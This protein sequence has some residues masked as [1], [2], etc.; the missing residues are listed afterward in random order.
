MLNLKLREEFRGKKLRG[1]MVDFTNRHG[2]G[3]LDKSAQEFLNITYPSVD[4]LKAVEALQPGKAKP[5]VIIGARGLGKSHLMA[6]LAHMYNDPTATDSWLK[7]WENQLNRDDLSNLNL[8]SN[9]HA[10]TESLHLHNYK[11]LWD[12]L[13]DKHPEGDYIKG[14]WEGQGDNKTDVLG[15]NLLMEMFQKQPTVLILDEFQT[16]YEG[17]TNTKQHPRRNWAFNFIQ[18]L[19]EISESNPELLKLIISVREGDSD[20]AQ[21]VYRVDPVRVDFKGP[22]AKR[23]RQKLLLY[24]IFENRI[25]IPENDIGNLINIHLNEFYR[26]HHIAGSEQGHHKDEFIHSWPFSPLLLQLLDDQV[27]IATHTQETRD[28]LRILVDVFKYAGEKRP[29]LTPADFSIVDEKSGVTSLLDSV[30]NNL[31]RD[32]RSK[33][34]RNYE[35]VNEALEGTQQKVPHLDVI[36]S[37]LWLR[38]LSLEKVVGARPA[39]IQL[40]ITDSKEIDDNLFSVELSTIEENSFNIH[41][42]GDRLVFLNEENPQAKLMAHAKNNRLFE[43]GQDIEHLAQEIRYVLAGKE[44]NSAQSRIVVLKKGWEHNP[45]D[46]VDERDRPENWDNRITHFVVPKGDIKS[47]ELGIW[48]QKHVQKNRNSVR[49]ILAKDGFDQVFYDKALLVLA[50]AVYLAKD[51]KNS[52]NNYSAL[53]IKYQKELRSQLCGRFDRFAILDTWNFGNP[54]QC[55]FEI[56]SHKAEGEYIIPKIQEI[57]RKDLF[58]AEDFDEL[59]AKGAENNSTIAVI[60]NQLKEPLG[61]DQQS[62]PWLGEVE[63]KENIIRLC[64][65]GKIQ[66]NLQGRDMLC[67]RPG[68]TKEAAW[69]RMKGKIGTGRVLEETTLH[70]PEST[71]SSGGGKT[72]EKEDTG[73]STSGPTG[74]TGSESGTDSG[75]DNGTGAGTTGG[76][77]TPGGLFGG[78]TGS[79]ERKRLQSDQTSALNL[80]GKLES[81]GV[82]TGDQVSNVKLSV[83]N[84]T[85]AQLQELIKKLPDGIA[86][87][88]EMEKEE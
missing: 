5:V 11:F 87:G 58:I 4:L 68:E 83:N 29:V 70:E 55:V 74:E 50:R 14:K 49:F 62:I 86:Y 3:A 24:R 85:G 79:T 45:W 28:L 47:K 42:K 44:Q 53:Y 34:L 63:A 26:L 6:A 80:L 43:D 19:S 60:I 7:S 23:D 54:D 76:P 21:Q 39:D 35:A 84:M 22:E 72:E 73:D 75:N 38:S 8:D 18:I 2:T 66:I 36:L 67:S 30:A 69:N 27:L 71:I 88:I 77:S 56:V 57:V 25:Q 52:D 82:N 12:L 48:L 17:L 40:D 64:A 59:V 61:G 81:W 13:F 16:W 33:A 1:T 10:I 51:W 65:R 31:H 41:R 32:L 78:D 46:E 9:I 37:S 20:A 15:H